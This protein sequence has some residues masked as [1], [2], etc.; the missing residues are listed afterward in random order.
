M[1]NAEYFHPKQSHT[2]ISYGT[3]RR[4]SRFCQVG[5]P[6]VSGSGRNFSPVPTRPARH[7]RPGAPSGRRALPG[8]TAVGRADLDHLDLRGPHDF[9]HTFSTWLEDAGIPARVI[10]E[11]MGHQRSR[12]GELDGGSRIGA[13]YRHTTA[14]M[15]ARVVD[16]IE[17]R[18]AVVLQVAEDTP[19][20]RQGTRSVF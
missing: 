20:D 9:R 1:H 6:S 14:D 4:I 10:D 3:M 15:A 11:L 16:A 5:Q 17:A 19:A 13:R 8:R 2:M 7:C 18:L 12:R